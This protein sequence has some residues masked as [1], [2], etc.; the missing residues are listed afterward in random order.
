M[1]V[2]FSEMSLSHQYE[3]I[4]ED[5]KNLLVQHLLLKAD[6]NIQN[7]RNGMTARFTDLTM[8]Y[9]REQIL[10]KDGNPLKYDMCVE[11]VEGDEPSDEYCLI[12]ALS[13]YDFTEAI[14]EAFKVYINRL[15]LYNP[16]SIIGNLNV[17]QGFPIYLKMHHVPVCFENGKLI[18]I[19]FSLT[20]SN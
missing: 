17:N 1:S 12:S 3:I 19:E 11:I 13:S 15:N 2:I 10:S 4:V 7:I 20:I 5:V 9:K 18:T 14:C 6:G 16:L 8:K